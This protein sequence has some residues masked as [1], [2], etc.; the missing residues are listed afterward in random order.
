MLN[1]T[2]G[3]LGCGGQ[4]SYL[5]DYLIRLGVKKI[6]L[7]DGDCFDESNLN[8]QL[9]SSFITLGQN[10][11]IALVNY[12]RTIADTNTEII[13]YP[14]F[15]ASQLDDYKLLLECDYIFDEMD[16]SVAPYIVRCELK[17][18][19]LEGIPISAGYNSNLGSVVS[20]QTNE[21][22]FDIV[23][24]NILSD[25]SNTQISQP[26]YLCAATASLDMMAMIK[27]FTHQKHLPLNE[28][29]Y[30]DFYHNNI[31]C[32]DQFGEYKN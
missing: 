14:K 5:V 20:I 15:F 7:F 27:Y 32:V 13:A 26:A 19:L 28:T 4:G 30:Y 12:C 22:F 25:N 16:Y 3:I 17:K 10:K 29:F 6:I 31:A 18:L 11:A 9:A 1:K 23:T 24:E 8:R 21:S 2:F